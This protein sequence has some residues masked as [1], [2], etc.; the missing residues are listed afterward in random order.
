MFT[1]EDIQ[2]IGSLNMS[3]RQLLGLGGG[4]GDQAWDEITNIRLKQDRG[5]RYW[6]PRGGSTDSGVT[7]ENHEYGFFFKAR[8][9]ASVNEYFARQTSLGDVKV[10]SYPDYTLIKTISG[11]TTTGKVQFVPIGQ[12]L[13]MFDGSQ[14][15]YLN[16]R[17]NEVHGYLS[18]YP[19]SIES[20]TVET[21]ASASALFTFS[22]GDKALIFPPD[23]TGLNSTELFFREQGSGGFGTASFTLT[24]AD[25]VDEY[26]KVFEALLSPYSV[27][28]WDTDAATSNVEFNIL[29][30]IDYSWTDANGFMYFTVAEASLLQYKIGT[31]TATLPT[32]YRITE[33]QVSTY[34]DFHEVRVGDIYSVNGTLKVLT[35]NGAYIDIDSSIFNIIGYDESIDSFIGQ[36][37]YERIITETTDAPND[38]ISYNDTGLNLA[39]TTASD[40]QSNRVF[41]KTYVIIDVL[42]DGSAVIN[43]KP[44][45]KSIKLY[46]DEIGFTITLSAA[47]SNVAKRYLCASRYMDNKK[48]T[49]RPST[50]NF[51]N[52]P[53]FIV[54]ELDASQT[55]VFDASPNGFLRRPVTEILPMAAGIP[56]IFGKGQLVPQTTSPH[57]DI[58]VIGGYKI[59]RPIPTIYTSL[60]ATSGNIF[61]SQSGL[62]T[63]NTAHFVFEYTDGTYSSE[64]TI[65]VKDGGAK[66]YIHS[67]NT[68]VEKIHFYVDDGTTTYKID[69][70]TQ[71][72]PE[73]MGYGFDIPTAF[74]GYNSATI[75]T[76]TQESVTLNNY[77][78][79]PVPPQQIFISG[80]GKVFGNNDIIKAV[81][82]DY[83]SDKTTLRYKLLIF[84]D[85]DIQVGYVYEVPDESNIAYNVDFEIVD[86]ARRALSEEGISRVGGSVFFQDKNGIHAFSGGGI[87]K[88]I[89]K[90]RYPFLSN[91]MRGV[92]YNESEDEL[93]FLFG[94]GKIYVI[95][96]DDGYRSVY[97]YGNLSI[98]D[99]QW[100]DDKLFLLTSNQLIETDKAGTTDDL[101]TAITGIAI[102]RYLSDHR[103]QL[104]LHEVIV[105]GIGGDASLYIDDGEARRE[106][107]TSSPTDFQFVSSDSFTAQN[108]KVQGALFTPRVRG[109]RPR[110]K[111]ELTGD[112]AV[113]EIELKSSLLENEGLARIKP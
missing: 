88:V 28:K 105:Y 22:E 76:D 50:G 95:G 4:D 18:A 91:N 49:V 5:Y 3:D 86:Q 51:N 29:N 90:E 53:W 92:I 81:P 84:T 34:T 82:L 107:S 30:E 12:L 75:P 63:A 40:D 110:I 21:T 31:T 61:V 47:S 33:S 56:T 39:G 87:D 79:V 54:K 57:K 19:T 89:P 65:V 62:D 96:A 113:E 10:Y 41:Y 11:F 24:E 74:S 2:S 66:G 7:A 17:T 98:N 32:L 69:T 20:A 36:S 109:V 38:I 72:D 25:I 15:K 13:Y 55:S 14:S 111:L 78:T 43:G 94:G 100:Y 16:L 9:G 67:L 102:S 83:D 42:D 44:L 70:F 71:R 46:S 93:W 77:V 58:F 52:S 35:E 27:Y 103:T 26:G 99:G 108:S 106:D 1:P 6:K 59:N 8:V 85:S 48:D 112:F 37:K 80:Q 101:G 60:P 104:M 73:F 68:L 23:I 45:T 64:A 97:D